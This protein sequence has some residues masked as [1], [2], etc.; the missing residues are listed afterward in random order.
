M[1]SAG[2]GSLGAWQRFERGELP[3]LD[4]YK[5]FSSDLSD[6][7]NGNIWYRAYCEKR[8]IGETG[9]YEKKLIPQLTLTRM[10]SSPGGVARERKGGKSEKNE[11]FNSLNSRECSA[12]RCDDEHGECVRRAH[13]PRARPSTRL[14]WDSMYPG[15][16]RSPLTRSMAASGRYRLIALTNNFSRNSTENPIP[17]EEAAFLGWDHEGA[18][19]QKLRSLFDDFC[20][21]SELGMR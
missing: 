7:H 15:Q 5:G 4:F 8:G 3:L 17:D 14:V 11:A 18:T 13:Q 2:R 9:L 20:D 1:Y 19:P 6:T 12:I 21:S 16:R 10:P